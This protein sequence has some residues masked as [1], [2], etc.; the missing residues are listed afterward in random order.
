[1]NIYDQLVGVGG[2]GTGLC[3]ALEGDHDLGRNESRAALLMPAID[4]CKLHIITHYLAVILRANAPADSSAFRLVPIGRVGDDAYGREL[5]NEMERV[6]ME[7]N[8]VFIS[9]QRPTLFS[10]CWLYPNK[11]GGNIT[12]SESAAAE[13]S[14][15]DVDD[16]ALP[17][18]TAGGK[19]SIALAVPE[20]PLSVRH[21]LL[22]LATHQGCFRAASFASAEMQTALRL[23]T[24]SLVDL[25]AVNEDEAAMIVGHELN[26]DAPQTFLDTCAANLRAMQPH[27]RIIISAGSYGAYALDKDVWHHTPAMDVQVTNTAGAGDA[28]LAGVLAALVRKLPLTERVAEKNTA[29]LERINC[30]LDFGVM[31]A[32][33]SATACDAI[34]PRATPRDLR[35]FARASHLKFSDAVDRA[36]FGGKQGED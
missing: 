33:Y 9:S 27:M 30:A 22:E 5:R 23:N 26:A 24:F 16:V 14:A 32:G 15:A 11:D 20:A 12:T 17:L 13:L 2:I 28:L 18:L 35:R 25:L 6:G 19:R 1:M 29:T 3:F 36:L 10:V 31:L 8:G 4:R 21:H 34:H 7:T